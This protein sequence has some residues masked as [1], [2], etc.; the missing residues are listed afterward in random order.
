MTATDFLKY[1][2]KEIHTAVA[3]TVDENGLPVTCAV[4]I[5]DSDAS[6]L[7]FL[8]AKGKGLYKRLKNRGYM[9]L[10]G[11][12][13]ESTMSCV[14][15]SVQG[16]VKELGS[17]LLQQL[18]EKNPYMQE[19]YPTKESQKALT[20]FA[21]YQGSG[22]W[23]DL[24][25]K[26]I[27]RFSFAF[28]QAKEEKEGYFI[29]SA[30]NGCRICE[31][32][33]PQNCIDFTAIPSVIRQ[34]NCLRCGNCINVCPQNAVIRGGNK[35][36]TQAERRFYLIQGL[37]HEQPRF[38]DQEIPADEQE[39]KNLLRLLLNIRMPHPVSKEFLKVQD[40]YLQE[41][42]RRKGITDFADLKPVQ[43]GLYLWKGDITTLCCDAIVNAANSQMLG[44]F[45]PCH[46]CID[47]AIHTFSGI[48]LRLACAEL[49]KKQGHKEETGKAK[50]TPA[51]NLPCNYVLHTVGPVVYG[52]LT[53]QE[54]ELLASCYRACLALADQNGVKSIAFCC[55][56]TGEFHFP[57]DK[58]AEIAI[59]TVK[60]YKKQTHSEIQVIFNV[61]KET[62]YHIYR[63]LLSAD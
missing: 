37:L 7:Y 2:E 40:V 5:M 26:P 56:S 16:K 11:I 49:M 14:A 61:F 50:I 31:R 20:V 51:F 60:N 54:K 63:K 21:L 9:A 62:D 25:K 57:N 12:K 1:L 35:E 33:C 52:G 47:N 4:D 53:K 23:F 17:A 28:G 38:S 55:I 24:S 8:T 58:A 32:V 48:Q 44:C 22:E 59:R 13:G 3:A 34:E 6:N 36:M 45:I 42:I 27:E 43:K 19:I 10:T 46:G 15:V 18:F 39:Q 41:E 30:C 29:T